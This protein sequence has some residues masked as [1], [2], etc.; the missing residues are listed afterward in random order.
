[1]TI[2]LLEL[3]AE[4]LIS[5][6]ALLPIQ[7]VYKFSHCSRY[8]RCLANSSLH[9]LNL[10]F[11]PPPHRQ[12]FYL[13]TRRVTLP[14]SSK[15]V[16]SPLRR[17]ILTEH[18]QLCRMSSTTPNARVSLDEEGLHK[19]LVLI[20]DAQAYEYEI[21]INFHSSLL[22]CILARYHNIQNL[23]IFVW[24]LTVPMAKAIPELAGLRS[25]SIVV[26]ETVYARTA[27][28]DY[29]AVQNAAW[30]VLATSTA[31]TDRLRNIKIQNADI[32]EAE[33]YKFLEHAPKCLELRIINCE[34]V[35]T[36]LW[37]FLG[38]EWKGRSTLR[39]LKI[40]DC[41]VILNEAAL[42]AIDKMKALQVIQTH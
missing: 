2:S 25:L 32:I 17:R 26:H 41:G 14:T 37:H 29:T 9:T 12:D 34:A 18:T 23:D 28:R 27:Q 40:A 39:F 31:W 21:L 7:D 3:P 35:S 11:C 15:H 24:A 13:Y 30:Q 4:L 38:D 10:D 22:S 5:T 16:R 19:V 1:M 36:A 20:Q 8:A 42:K 33:M 6:L